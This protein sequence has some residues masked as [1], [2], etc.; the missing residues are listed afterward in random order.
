VAANI[1]EGFAR[2]A[3]RQRVAFL[4]ISQSSLA[5]VDYCVHVAKRLGYLSEESVQA[6][7]TAMKQVCWPLAGLIRSERTRMMGRSAGVIVFMAVMV[8][9]VVNV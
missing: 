3:G 1:A 4:H 9:L 2:P 7:N 5:E 8:R 6:L